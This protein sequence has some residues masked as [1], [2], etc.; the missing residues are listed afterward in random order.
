M[1]PVLQV[2]LTFLMHFGI[3]VQYALWSLAYTQKRYLTIFY[4]RTFC[5]QIAISK[6]GLLFSI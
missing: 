6:G 3:F 1:A 5:V 2:H 4:T